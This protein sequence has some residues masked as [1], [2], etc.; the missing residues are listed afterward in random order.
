MQYYVQFS[1]QINPDPLEY[2]HVQSFMCTM[3]FLNWKKMADKTI[4]A[5]LTSIPIELNVIL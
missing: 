3:D 4:F 5:P 1:F 2:D